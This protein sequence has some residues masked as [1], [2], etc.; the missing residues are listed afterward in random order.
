MRRDLEHALRQMRRSPGFTLAA[1]LTLAIG[2]GATT[3]IF[4]LIHAAL[5]RPLP[6]PEADRLVELA[7]ELPLDAGRDTMFAWSYP[8]YQ[9]LRELE[10]PFEA[11]AG[12]QAF[13]LNLTGTDRPERLS[14]EIVSGEYL[15]L[16]GVRAAFG[17]TFLPEEDATPRTHPVVL[18]SHGLW[19]RRYG[20]DPRVVGAEVE[21]NG[22]PLTVVGVLPEGFRG[23]SGTAEAWVPMMMAP[24]LTY[25]ERLE[26]RWSHWHGVVGRLAAGVSLE[27]ARA[28]LPALASAVG[29]AHVSPAGGGPDWGMLAR[30]LEEA[31]LDPELRRAAYVLLGAVGFV[32]LIG[33]LNVAGLLLARAAG[34]R[35][36]VAIRLAVGADRRRLLRQFLVESLAL[37]LLGGAVGVLVAVWAVD[38][39]AA[40]APTLAGETRLSPLVDLR[41]VGVDLPV[42]GFALAISILTGLLFGLAPALR[43]CR[44][45]AVDALHGDA[46][47]DLLTRRRDRR[48]A[49]VA[50]EVALALVLLVGAGLMVRSFS[51]LRGVPIGF[52]PE[53]VLTFRLQPAGSQVDLAGAP[54]FYRELIERL[55]GLPGVEGV[56]VN[57]CAPL[58]SACMGSL[59]VRLDG[60]ELTPDRGSSDIGV[61]PVN[62]GYFRTLDIPLV[63]GRAFDERDRAD[64][65]LVA[66]VNESAARA[67]WP[68]E[69]PLGRRIGV[70]SYP[71]GDATA[72]V[73]GVVGDVRY[74]A[75]EAP[76][77][78][79]VY[80]ATGQGGRP[81]ATVFVRAAGDPSALLPAIRREM[82][83]LSPDL[84]IF[85]V[86]TL[87]DR[88]AEASARA[89]FSTLLLGL[90]AAVA[91]GLALIGIYGTVAYTVAERTREL[92]LRRAL[93]ASRR[94]VLSL[95]V[96]GVLAP[97]LIGLAVGLVVSLALTRALGRLLYGVGA[98]DPL[99]FAA[100][101]LGL[102][103]A[104]LAAGTVPAR[105]ATRVDPMLVLRAE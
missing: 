53:R 24:A 45:D 36:E 41:D 91:L 79:D 66:I 31:R 30:P 42:L 92:G 96:R 25:D 15:P 102:L 75:L 29:E 4:S 61:H 88:V 54:A 28:R 52:A 40:I 18:L 62:G 77:R 99:T 95:V 103:L 6:Y 63:R 21:V 55:E 23:L 64:A 60:Q 87:E 65:P 2:I 44:P 84:P 78:P 104:A 51:A 26:E 93:G 43:A 67:L 20:A 80:V 27:A 10:H 86:A 100:V 98:L 70:A 3:A 1:V 83:A 85:D 90:F 50:V 59:V 71:F 33:C 35:R 46:S 89:R 22:V 9:T 73:V 58:S 19:T 81:R 11:L 32:L 57:T 14:V 105:R 94:R 7:F 69:D 17:R 39:L 97:T 38:A 12:Y 34:R 56:G 47:T 5:L 74:G 82:A 49:L 48:G 68:G 101:A 37:A 13:D 72:E 8:K 76:S 16:L